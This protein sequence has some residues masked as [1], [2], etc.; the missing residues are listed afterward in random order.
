MQQSVAAILLANEGVAQVWKIRLQQSNGCPILRAFCEGW[1]ATAFNSRILEPNGRIWLRFMVPTLR[2]EREGWGTH[3]FGAEP[4]LD[5]SD[6]S[7]NL[8]CRRH[9]L[10]QP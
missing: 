3:H 8:W 4:N 5:K 9:L 1:D 2:K 10:D 7:Y 6:S